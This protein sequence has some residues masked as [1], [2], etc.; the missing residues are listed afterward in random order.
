MADDGFTKK[1]TNGPFKDLAF[2]KVEIAGDTTHWRLEF[3][4]GYVALVT[5]LDYNG[6]TEK[7]CV[8]NH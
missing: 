8:T 7:D 6:W 3:F 4:H 5:R 2:R 1:F